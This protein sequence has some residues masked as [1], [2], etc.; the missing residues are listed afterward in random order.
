MAGMNY[1]YACSTL[2]F[3]S[4]AVAA[5]SSGGGAD[6][7][8]P[9]S[10]PTD[11]SRGMESG[12]TNAAAT[13]AD[14]GGGTVATEELSCAS[15]TLCTSYKVATYRGQ[16]LPA[17]AGGRPNGLYRLAYRLDK[18]GMGV[19]RSGAEVSAL[20]F[21]GGKFLG[22]GFGKEALGTAVVD[23]T[24][25]TFT[26]QTNCNSETG[27][28]GSASTRTPATFGFSVDPTSGNLTIIYDQYGYAE[29]YVPASAACPSL[30]TTVPTTPGESANCSVTNCGCAE[31]TNKAA[32]HAT[33]NF[34]TGHTD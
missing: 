9:A 28:A 27:A 16:P 33:C 29:V 14:G 13:A 26:Y 6:P 11:P 17:P 4:F 5:C 7:T 30:V 15:H 25:L 18:D 31:G 32:N 10:Q 21:A 3:L 23:G 12:G 34:V 22:M 2:V 24:R 19:S 8:A 20:L 1:R